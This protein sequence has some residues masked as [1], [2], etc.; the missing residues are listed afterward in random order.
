[1]EVVPVCPSKPAPACA[2]QPLGCMGMPSSPT[3][4]LCGT[5]GAFP[6]LLMEQMLVSSWE[7]VLRGVLLGTGEL[8]GCCLEY[9]LFN[10]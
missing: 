7:W 6:A 3:P 4:G 8:W 2:G 5:W 1:M 10:Y 9:F